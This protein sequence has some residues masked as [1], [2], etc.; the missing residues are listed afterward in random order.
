MM[1]KRENRI[2]DI[3][4]GDAALRAFIL[5]IQTSRLVL[6]YADI[7]LHKKVHLSVSKLIVLQALASNGFM[8]PSEIARWTQTERH[9]ITTLIDR[10]RQEGLVKAERDKNDKRIV[11]VTLMEKGREILKQTMPMAKEVV[12]QVMLSITESDVALL[13]KLLTVLK[14]NADCGL[15]KLAERS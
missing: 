6:K 2:V 8:K 10:M 15:E 4:V 3:P 1:S 7:H 11:I 9:N 5:F 14:K 13:Q 12:D